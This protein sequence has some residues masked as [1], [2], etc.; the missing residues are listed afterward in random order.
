MTPLAQET[1]GLWTEALPSLPRSLEVYERDDLVWLFEE[2]RRTK[3][4]VIA[5]L[6]SLHELTLRTDDHRI[7]NVN[8]VLHPTAICKRSGTA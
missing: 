8:P 5:V 4:R 1:L 3:A 6:R 7:V 2:G